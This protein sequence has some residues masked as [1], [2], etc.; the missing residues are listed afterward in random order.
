MFKYK[1]VSM[2]ALLICMAGM[3]LTLTTWWQT[4]SAALHPENKMQII[5]GSADDYGH[6]TQTG[7][8]YTIKGS[9]QETVIYCGDAG[10]ISLE[11]V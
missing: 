2:P 10:P 9:K 6:V 5:K 7:F 11:M 4:T 1:A 8:F 3:R